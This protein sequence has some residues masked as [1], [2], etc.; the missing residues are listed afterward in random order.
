MSAADDDEDRG[1]APPHDIAMDATVTEDGVQCRV[2]PA[3]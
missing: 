1:F 2:A 3:P